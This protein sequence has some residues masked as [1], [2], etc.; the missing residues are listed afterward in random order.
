[1]GCEVFSEQRAGGHPEAAPVF[2]GYFSDASGEV[3]R[4][5]KY[6]NKYTNNHAT[7]PRRGIIAE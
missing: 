1:M 3:N 2:P 4:Q 6:T 7:L 5:L